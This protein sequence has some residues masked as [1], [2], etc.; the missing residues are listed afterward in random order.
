MNFRKKIQKRGLCLFQGLLLYVPSTYLLYVSLG[1]KSLTCTVQT[2]NMYIELFYNILSDSHKS[3]KKKL[4][5]FWLD[6]KKC[7]EKSDI[8]KSQVLSRTLIGTV[9][10]IES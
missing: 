1:K 4:N 2:R 10:I 8:Y 5:A 6:K 7:C 3:D 9:L